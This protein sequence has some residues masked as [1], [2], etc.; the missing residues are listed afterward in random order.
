MKKRGGE[1]GCLGCVK[2]VPFKLNTLKCEFW[3][4]IK[5]TRKV[6]HYFSLSVCACA[7]VCMCVRMQTHS[8]FYDPSLFEITASLLIPKSDYSIFVR[9]V[10]P[11]WGDHPVFSLRV[12]SIINLILLE[13]I[14]LTLFRA[15]N[16]ITLIRVTFTPL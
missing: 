7:C 14:T 8:T 11:S 12:N 6:V 5:Y 13:W 16:L 3:W 15:K 1:G 10:S 2:A 9:G 4:Y